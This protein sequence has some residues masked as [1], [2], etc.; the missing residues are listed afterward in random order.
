MYAELAGL[1]TLCS[2]GES[3]LCGRL[4]VCVCVCVCQCVCVCVC[5]NV[6]QVGVPSDS[7]FRTHGGVA[8]II[9]LVLLAIS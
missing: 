1:L 4:S 3:L 9:S 2:V 8:T 7:R 6:R 5:V